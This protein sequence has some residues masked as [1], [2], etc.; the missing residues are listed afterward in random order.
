MFT[1]ISADVCARAWEILLPAIEKAATLEVTARLTGTVIVLDP[2]SPSHAIL[3]TGDVGAP[4]P[5]TTEWAT[6]KAAVALRTGMDTSR[7]RQDFPHLYKEGD[8]KWEGGVNRD[9][10]VVAFSGVQGYFDEMISE[11]MISAIRGICRDEMLR[12]GGAAAAEGPY[13]TS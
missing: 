4:N 3:F 1:G 2:T 13:L 12:E 11:W 6:A 7:V 10:L 9:G 8:I 5:M